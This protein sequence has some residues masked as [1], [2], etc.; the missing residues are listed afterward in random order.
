MHEEQMLKK[1]GDLITRVNNDVSNAKDITANVIKLSVAS[2]R[3][4]EL[5]AIKKRKL[6]KEE[7]R[8]SYKFEKGPLYK[9]K[10]SKKAVELTKEMLGNK[11]D[12][13]PGRCLE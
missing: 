12:M 4:Q 11:A 10:R 2:L 6:V 13:P 8:K 7:K 3:H 5:T 9:L 1:E